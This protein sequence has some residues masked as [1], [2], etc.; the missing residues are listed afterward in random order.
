M[1]SSTPRR[2]LQPLSLNLIDNDLEHGQP[3]GPIV[4]GTGRMSNANLSPK[5]DYS[6]TTQKSF[7]AADAAHDELLVQSDDVAMMEGMDFVDM[8]RFEDLQE[9]TGLLQAQRSVSQSKL[10]VNDA[11]PPS[12]PLLPQNNVTFVSNEHYR[13]TIAEL[14]SQIR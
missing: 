10:L 5:I 9:T 12:I 1:D 8:D 14:I 13:Q 2:K 11:I 6:K 4:L 3:T 7:F